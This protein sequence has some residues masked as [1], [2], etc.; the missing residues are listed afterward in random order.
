MSISSSSRTT[1][2]YM[3]VNDRKA[4]ASRKR[5]IAAAAFAASAT[6]EDTEEEQAEVDKA[7]E[8]HNSAADNN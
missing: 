1:S 6:A 8:Q 7:V 5:A 3:D 4:V 2:P